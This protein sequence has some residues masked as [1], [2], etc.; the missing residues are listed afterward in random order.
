MTE[1]IRTFI[2]AKI[3]HSD[4]EKIRG[5][6]RLLRNE[7][8]SIKWVK[9]ENLHLTLR[10]LGNIEISLADS[11]IESIDKSL[12]G[13][14]ILNMNFSGLGVFPDERRPRVLWTGLEGDTSKLSVISSKLCDSLNLQGFPKGKNHFSPHITIGRFSKKN[15]EKN[16]FEI[17]NKYNSLLTGFFVI[18]EIVFYKSELFKEGAKYSPLFT[19][20]LKK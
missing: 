16:L 6:Q 12:D 15:V 10:F 9:P 18:D 11:V 20:T 8:K 17:I 3:S 1:Q 2:A 14:S 7:I 5:F 4:C 19:K 13:F